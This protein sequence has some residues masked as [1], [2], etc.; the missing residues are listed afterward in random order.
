[1]FRRALLL[2]LSVCLVGPAWPA[3][4]QQKPAKPT[5][6]KVV[7]KKDVAAPAVDKDVFFKKGDRVVFLGDSITMVWTLLT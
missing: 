5:D 3:A 2:V 6:P 1:M 4:A 7:D